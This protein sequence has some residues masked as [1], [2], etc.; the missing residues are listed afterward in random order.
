MSTRSPRARA[1]AERREEAAAS[2]LD[3]PFALKTPSLTCP[4]SADARRDSRTLGGNWDLAKAHGVEPAGGFPPASEPGTGRTGHT[5]PGWAPVPRGRPALGPCLPRAESGRGGGPCSGAVTRLSPGGGTPHLRVAYPPPNLQGP[6]PRG[7][8]GGP[9]V[10]GTPPSRCPGATGGG[11]V[12]RGTP[13]TG[14]GDGRATGEATA[15]LPAL[16]SRAGPAREPGTRPPPPGREGNGGDSPSGAGGG[17]ELGPAPR[18]GWG[19]PPAGAAPA[20]GAGRRAPGGCR[21]PG[22]GRPGREAAVPGPAPRGLPAPPVLTRPPGTP[23]HHHPPPT[24]PYRPAPPR[25]LTGPGGSACGCGPGPGPDRR[26]PAP[27]TR[28]TGGGARAR[29]GGGYASSRVWL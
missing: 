5:A 19:H 9:S 13:C 3:I 10:A 18:R 16:G 17:A 12:T 23:G 29:A 25:S 27:R 4:E 22:R 21:S 1:A 15:L 20:E 14:L 7:A 6:E 11:E 28:R 24:P 8:A 2:A 26:R